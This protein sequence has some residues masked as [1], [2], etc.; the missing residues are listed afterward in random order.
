MTNEATLW[1]NFKRSIAEAFGGGPRSM[2]ISDR[3]DALMLSATL[4]RP[5]QDEMDRRL[6]AAFE[7][8]N[9]AHVR[10]KRIADLTE[11]EFDEF[12]EYLATEQKKAWHALNERIRQA[13]SAP[14][15][16]HGPG[17]PGR[18]SGNAGSSR[19]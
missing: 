17:D 5:P 10:V 7:L 14:S 9:A 13:G 3:A 6:R 8:W 11:A 1:N 18:S 15:A 12:I 19:S 4:S 2:A 16:Y